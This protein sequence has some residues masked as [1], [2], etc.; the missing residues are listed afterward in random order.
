MTSWPRPTEQQAQTDLTD[1]DAKLHRLLGGEPVAW[2]LRRA[3]DRLEAGRPL[4]GLVT[5]PAAT[6]EQRRAVERLTG[7]AARSG[8]SLS[9][10]LTEVDCIL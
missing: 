7:R 4:T 8:A 3:R 6:S 2:L 9:V 10:S 5:L 1:A